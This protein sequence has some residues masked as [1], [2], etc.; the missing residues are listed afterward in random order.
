MD[1][2]NSYKNDYDT[3]SIRSLRS[4]TSGSVS[5]AGRTEAMSL[6]RPRTDQEIEDRFVDFMNNMGMHEPE[7]RKAMIGLTVDN[8]WKLIF[9]HESQEQTKAKKR[10]EEYVDKSSPEYFVR[11]LQLDGDL[12]VTDLKFLLALFVSLKSQPISWVRSFIQSRGMLVLSN[13]LSTLSHRPSRRESDLA[14]ELEIVKCLKPLLNN[15]WEAQEAIKHSSCIT[16]LCFSIAS[17][18][19]QTR[20]LVVEVLT[21]LC[22]CEVSMGHKLVL[23]GLDQAMEYWKESARFDAWMRIL[24]NTIDGRGRF[25]TMVGMSEELKKAGTQDGQL[26]EYVKMRDLKYDL[27]DR[28]LNIYEDEAENDYEDMIGFYNHQILH[29]MSDP[30]DVFHALLRSVESSRAY[31]FFLSLLQYMLLIREEGDFRIRYFQLMDAIVTQVVL[32]RRG[33]TDNFDQKLGISVNQLVGKLVDQDRLNQATED[34]KQARQELELVVRQ[35]NELELEVGKKD[36]GMVSQLKANIYSLEDLLRLSRYTIQTL[37][38]KLYDVETQVQNKLAIQDT[39]LKHL[40]KSLQ[41]ANGL[42]ADA[43]MPTSGGSG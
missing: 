33:I 23:E 24:E 39:Q 2:S 15:R 13:A 10:E 9:Q 3:Q 6:A 18:H 38:A 42:M 19:L 40:L 25:G 34:S 31:D 27:I 1:R 37:Q 11:K 16:S 5:E 36:D 35:K 29:D 14:M 12:K 22:Y 43:G 21:F 4:S 28:Q 30:Y 41:D 7:Q 20:K 32:D 17:P 8:K 26:I